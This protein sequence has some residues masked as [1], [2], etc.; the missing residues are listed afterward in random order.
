MGKLLGAL[1]KYLS[2][3]G[4]K[5]RTVGSKGKGD[6]W[7]PQQREELARMIVDADDE[8]EDRKSQ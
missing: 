7:T 3:F 8:D 1:R 4:K 6:Y 2:K 5:G